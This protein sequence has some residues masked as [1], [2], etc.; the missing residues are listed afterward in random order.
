MVYNRDGVYHASFYYQDPVS[1]ARKR[2]RRS[3]GKTRKREA[4]TI[5]MQW[6]MELETPPPPPEEV[7]KHA[8]FSGFA[9][10]WINI[11]AVN[12]KPS[13]LDSYENILRATLV[14]WFKDTDLRYV[15]VEQVEAFKAQ[16]ARRGRAHKT[17]NNYLGV[18]SRMFRSAIDWGYAERNPFIQAGRLKEPPVETEFWDA[19]QSDAFLATARELEPEWYCFFLVALRT[20]MRQGE[21]FGL[22]W[23]DLDFVKRTIHVRRAVRKRV[24]STPKNNRFRRIPMTDQVWEALKA[25]RSL[26]SRDWVFTRE[27]GEVLT[28]NAIKWAFWR[29]TRAAGLPE[30]RFHDLRHSFASQLVMAGVPLAGVKELLGHADIKMTM[31]YSH[32]APTET[33]RYIQAL[34]NTEWSR[35]GHTGGSSLILLGGKPS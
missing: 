3:T 25:H 12:L 27:N 2:C 28:R 30:I 22:Q 4:M 1:G 33:A 18:G 11:H 29:L 15:S 10:H 34:E 17:V 20:G 32:L 23:K 6:K 9:R 21:I 8:A 13:S 35:F 26:R 19:E 31:R 7:K 14:P 16:M 5:A 24:V